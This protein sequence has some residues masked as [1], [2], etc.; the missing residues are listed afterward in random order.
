M[1]RVSIMH[2]IVSF[3]QQFKLETTSYVDRIVIHLSGSI[4]SLGFRTP[5]FALT[6]GSYAD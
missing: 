2:N 3:N 5:H 1:E 6:S 4:E